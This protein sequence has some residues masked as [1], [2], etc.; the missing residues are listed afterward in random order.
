MSRLVTLRLLS[1]LPE[2]AIVAASMALLA[3]SSALVG[4]RP[5]ELVQALLG[6]CAGA[7]LTYLLALVFW[8]VLVDDW[9]HPPE[10]DREP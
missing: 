4:V 5:W 9:D 3:T 1:M 8:P 10:E 2:V 6:I 7:T